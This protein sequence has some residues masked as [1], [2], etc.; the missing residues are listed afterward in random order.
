[1]GADVVVDGLMAGD[2]IGEHGS[3][4]DLL[5]VEVFILKR[6]EEALDDAVGLRRAVAGADVRELGPGG[7]VA[8]DVSAERRREFSQLR[9]ES[10]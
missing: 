6:L 10:L 8:G 1:M 9:I 5:A 3:V 7:D 2:G 4:A